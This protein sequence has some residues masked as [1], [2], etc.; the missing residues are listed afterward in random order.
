MLNRDFVSRLSTRDS[1]AIAGSLIGLASFLF[2]WFTLRPNRLASGVSFKLWDSAGWGATALI[3]GLWVVCLLL[4]WRGKKPWHNITA[5]IV[6][7]A[8]VIIAFLLARNVASQLPGSQSAIARVSLS[9]GVWLTL[10]GAY[11]VVFS[12]RQRLKGWPLWQNIISWSGVVGVIILL[13]SGWLDNLSVIK[14]FIG[15]EARFKQELVNHVLLAGGSVLAGGI[16]GVVLGIWA[17]KRRHAERPI[18]FIANITQAIPSLALFGLLMAPLS[19]LSFAFPVL[20]E[21]GIR[22]VGTAP[23][24]IALVLYSLL[25]V[26]RNTYV[27]LNQVEPAVIDAGTGMGMSRFQVFRRVEV[28]LSA[29]VVLEG[30]RI[31]AVQAVGNTAVAALIGAGGLGFF[32]FQGLG[33]AASDVIIMGAL[34]IMGLALVVDGLM[35]LVVRLATPPGRKQG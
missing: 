5:G 26:I 27:G 25:P 28:P 34:P 15:Q 7:N 19:A 3:L 9:S 23:A 30:V 24:L 20:R 33:Q 17:A 8:V 4:S 16:I 12:C 18:F 35:R 29:P 31:A 32:I 1:L 10:F 14:E 22:G 2:G 13:A 11:I 6:A 21:W